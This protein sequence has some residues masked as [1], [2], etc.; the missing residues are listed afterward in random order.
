MKKKLS[1]II[2]V[3][4][5]EKYIEKCLNSLITQIN[6][7]VEVIVVN[8]GSN[9]K[10]LEL[11][12]KYSEYINIF[13]KSNGG[14]SS[15]RN[16]GIE[17]ATG[18]YIAFID[19]DDWVYPNYVK[20]LLE[21]IEQK[22]YD[23][24]SFDIS[25]INDGWE[26]G[27]ER[28]LYTNIKELNTA[29]LMKECYN[30]SFA[31]ARIYKAN[32]FKKYRFP[33]EDY[34]YEDM[35]TI[36]ILISNSKSFYHI[37]AP[38]I[39]Y[40]QRDNSITKKYN[41]P[42]TLGVIKAWDLC[43][44]E[45]N[46]KYIEEFHFALYKSIVDFM[47]FKPEFVDKFMNYYNENKNDF[48]NNKYINKIIENKEYE[49]LSK[50]QIIPKKIHYCWF[51]KGAKGELFEK[52][53]DS[54]KKYAPG[55]EIIEWNESNCDINECQYVKEAYE[56]KKWAY[57]ADFFR[58][59]ALKENGG[60]YVDTDI[61]FTNYIDILRVNSTF[62]A[63]ETEDV[64]AAIFGCV[65]NSKTIDSLYKSYIF[66]KFIKPDGSFNTDYPIPK[67]ITSILKNNSNIVLNGKTQI[68]EDDVKIYSADI[69]TL[70]IYNDKNIATH[71]YEAT[72]WDVKMG[73]VSYKYTVLEHYFR[74]NNNYSH[75]CNICN[76]MSIKWCT[77]IL[78]KKLKQKVRR[79]LN[80]HKK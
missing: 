73:I 18:E 78:I 67:R 47:Y 33:K 43:K 41:N 70:N 30:P 76:E 17:K 56:N 54:W 64:N 52:C 71:H 68:L 55:Y 9:D 2:P 62:F 23:I 59:K 1:I 39:Y 10:S 40:R 35:A 7:E 37:K 36:P 25:Y 50:K 49:D 63:F 31:W 74:T 28:N 53:L 77:K 6:D 4:N 75:N 29:E 19:S 21:I 8:D 72:W 57:V 11:C 27:T 14:L 44:K 24:I 79:I 45:I 66:D 60:I 46:H 58:I 3:Y 61:E 80:G 13:T 42:K 15:A 22:K 20:K 38:L 5:V 12:K 26:N 32:L 65:K 16:Y 34:W 48:I 69:L 51:G